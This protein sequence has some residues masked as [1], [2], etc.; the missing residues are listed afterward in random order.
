MNKSVVLCGMSDRTL[1]SFRGSPEQVTRQCQAGAWEPTHFSSLRNEQSMEAGQEQ[2]M[3]NQGHANDT[4]KEIKHL[5]FLYTAL[6]V[7]GTHPV[8]RD[9][10]AA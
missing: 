6:Y 5:Y 3:G 2:P 10:L 7:H 4:V 8:G 1:S 9:S